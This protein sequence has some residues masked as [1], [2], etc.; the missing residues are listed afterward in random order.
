MAG[1]L[2]R[3]NR[4]AEETRQELQQD[5]KRMSELRT[6]ADKLMPRVGFNVVKIRDE[7]WWR[8]W[9][10]KKSKH[11][12][13]SFG[14]WIEEEAEPFGLG[15]RSKVYELISIAEN[16]REIPKSKVMEFG[17]SKCVQLARVARHKPKQLGKV[18]GLLEKNPEMPVREVMD[19]VANVLAGQHLENRV[20]RQMNFA[21][22]AEDYKAISQAIKVK[23]IMDPLPDPD[24][25]AAPGIH[26]ANMIRDFMSGA[27]QISVL[28]QLDKYGK[29][30]PG[31]VLEA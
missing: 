8:L 1:Q 21:L 27:E 12:F 22:N 17:H 9:T 3:S 13:E 30:K 31:F 25:F 26:L 14:Q 10:S 2:V 16:L 11:A 7:K 18:I 24:S 28:K 23:Q 6:E 20:Y 4:E 19:A 29:K 5:L 15:A